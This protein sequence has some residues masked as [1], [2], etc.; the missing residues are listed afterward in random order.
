[1][2]YV[3]SLQLLDTAA[4]STQLATAGQVPPPPAQVTSPQSAASVALQVAHMSQY[5][6]MNKKRSADMINDPLVW[7]SLYQSLSTSLYQ[8]L[9]LPHY[10]TIPL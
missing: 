6:S 8:S 7:F 9:S 10:L 5:L 4:G 3:I 2:L 1:M